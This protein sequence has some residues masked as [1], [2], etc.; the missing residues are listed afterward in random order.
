MPNSKYELRNN[1][2]QEIM[3]KPP[4]SFVAHGN[5]GMLAILLVAFYLL[6]TFPLYERE[7]THFEISRIDTGNHQNDSIVL[8]L[9]LNNGISKDVQP[10]QS[11]KITV[12]NLEFNKEDHLDG[13]IYRIGHTQYNV[14]VLY[15]KCGR[16]ALNAQKGMIGNLEIIIKERTFLSLLTDR[17][18]L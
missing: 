12:N 4:H 3:R 5:M 7:T 15:V 9:A 6:N 2:V 13:K 16:K 11:A 1:E 10:D 8:V 17:F 18:K 14:P